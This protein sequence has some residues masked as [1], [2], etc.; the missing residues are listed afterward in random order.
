V[1]HRLLIPDEPLTD[2]FARAL[3]ANILP[4]LREETA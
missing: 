1:Y 4:G 2:E 3:V